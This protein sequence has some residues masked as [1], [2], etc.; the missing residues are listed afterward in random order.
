MS[1][2]KKRLGGQHNLWVVD[3]YPFIRHTLRVAA[4]ARVGA[5]ELS[6]EGNQ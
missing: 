2:A 4:A 5:S 3:A 1:L 6:S